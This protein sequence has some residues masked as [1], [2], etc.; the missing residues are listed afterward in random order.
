MIPKIIHY[1]WFGGKP[2]PPLYQR[3]VD[4][5]AE[6]LPDYRVVRWDE[7]NTTFDTPFLQN[8]LRKQQW[9]FLSDYIRLRAIA[10]QGGIYLDADIEVVKSFDPLLAHQCFLGMEAPAR[11]TTGVIGSIADH[12]FPRACMRLI[13]ERHAARKPYL[14][15]PEVAM[16]CVQAGEAGSIAVLSEEHFYPYNPYDASR[17]VKELMFSSITQDTFAIHH[18]GKSWRQSLVSR[19]LKKLGF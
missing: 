15:A 7:T 19:I 9:A 16:A 14:I 17:P 13:D 4:S 8:C 10:D 2:L 3:C 1:C 6:R 5:W 11:P 18:W 12:W